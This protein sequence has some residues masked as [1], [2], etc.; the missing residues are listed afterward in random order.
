L[1][2]TAIEEEHKFRG[3]RKKDVDESIG[4]NLYEVTRAEYK[5]KIL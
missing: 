4:P 2:G 3:V 1:G 5:K